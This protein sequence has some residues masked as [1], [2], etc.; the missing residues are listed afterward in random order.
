[1]THCHDQT[2]DGEKKPL[3]NLLGS[4]LPHEE[5]GVL[6]HSKD[7]Y[8]WFSYRCAGPDETAMAYKE[9]MYCH[10]QRRTVISL[11]VIHGLY[12]YTTG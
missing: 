8:I 1:M 6:S 2:I 9:R 3:R 7:S 12:G 5:R 10:R 11:R 4:F